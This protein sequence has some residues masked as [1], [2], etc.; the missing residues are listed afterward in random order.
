MV[1]SFVPRSRC[2][3]ILSTS[4]AR[5]STRNGRSEWPL[6][7]RAAAATPWPGRRSTRARA[8]RPR[9]AWRPPCRQTRTWYETLTR[10]G[11]RARWGTTMSSTG[12]SSWKKSSCN[13]ISNSSNSSSRGRSRLA[14]RRTSLPRSRRWR[15]PRQRAFTRFWSGCHPRAPRWLLTMEAPARAPQFRSKNCTFSKVCIGYNW[16]L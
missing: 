2:G 13:C 8:T 7:A 14:S 5:A 11:C 3:P 10:R 15:C 12:S 9:E 4:V 6:P 1:T 16:K